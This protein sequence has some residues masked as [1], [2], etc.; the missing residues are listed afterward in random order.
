MA[1]RKTASGRVARCFMPARISS[2]FLTVTL[3]C[4]ARC[5]MAS[6]TK[7][8][9]LGM[10]TLSRTIFGFLSLASLPAAMAAAAVGAAAGF[11]LA[12][13]GAAAWGLATVFAAAVRA[14]AAFLAATGCLAAGL[15]AGAALARFFAAGARAGVCAGTA[16]AVGA[17]CAEVGAALVMLFFP[18]VRGL[19][20]TVHIVYIVFCILQTRGASRRVLR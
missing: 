1:A 3:S 14:G 13:A 5:F 8:S 18:C 2:V 17:A 12:A 20:K 4:A 6:S 16:L 15:R 9:A 11:A 10:V 19:Q 7:Y